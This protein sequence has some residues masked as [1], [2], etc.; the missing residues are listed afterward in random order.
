[1]LFV[2]EFSSVRDG[3]RSACQL[4]YLLE[5]SCLLVCRSVYRCHPLFCVCFAQLLDIDLF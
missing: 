5:F 4:H 3:F 1:M 2:Y